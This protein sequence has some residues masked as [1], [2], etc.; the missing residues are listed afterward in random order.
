VT[1]LVIEDALA[2]AVPEHLEPAVSKGPQRRVVAFVACPLGVVELA[3]PARVPEA[4]QGPLLDSVVEEVVARQALGHD[5]LGL[6]RAPRDRR[7][8]GVACE[9]VRRLER[10]GVIADLTGDPGGETVTEAGKGQVDLAARER[11]PHVGVLHGLV[12]S[13][14]WAAQEQLAH[15]LLPDSTLVAEE[16]ELRGSQCDGGGL[17]PH[18]VVPCAEVLDRERLADPGHELLRPAVVTGPGEGFEFG[19]A[20]PGQLVLGGPTLEHSQDSGRPEIVTAD[21]ERSRT[22]DDEVGPQP[23]DQPSLVAGGPFVISGDRT[24]LPRH[25]P[26]RDQGAEPRVAVERKQAGDA[27]VVGVVLLPRR[28]PPASD[29]IG[30]HRHH[31]VA[32]VHQSLDECPVTGLEHDMHLGRIGL[33]GRHIGDERRQGIGSMLQ[34]AHLHHAFTGTTN[35]DEVEVL[36]PVDA[37]TEHAASFRSEL[38]GPRAERRADG[39]VLVGRHRYGRQ[40]PGASPRVAV[41]YQSSKDKRRS[42]RSTA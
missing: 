3:S 31:D 1:L 28:I 17:R 40:G 12:A 2:Q 30:V 9:R 35:G 16:Q 42:P 14:V 38:T 10:F 32:R 8:A 4:G 33:H 29:E 21:R 6:A 11:L 27:G 7:L 36:G 18:E 23:V 22:H 20:R 13:G 41:S 37:D 25:L 19:V 24:Q 39:Q 5:D 26:V 15:A 34:A